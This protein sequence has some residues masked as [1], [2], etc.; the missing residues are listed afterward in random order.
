MYALS[1]IILSGMPVPQNHLN[2]INVN[3]D[4]AIGHAKTSKNTFFVCVYSENSD[5]FAI[6]QSVIALE[7][8]WQ[9]EQLPEALPS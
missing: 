3:Q 5:V 8:T 9:T 2:S 6:G 7:L 4:H 1:N